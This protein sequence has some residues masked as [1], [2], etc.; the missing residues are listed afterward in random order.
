MSEINMA[1]VYR[2]A[3]RRKDEI[4]RL[5][6]EIARLRAA[7]TKESESHNGPG[8]E[9]CRCALCEIAREGR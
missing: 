1:Q 2:E 9:L 8:Y 7:I 4:A 6:A 3:A 5:R